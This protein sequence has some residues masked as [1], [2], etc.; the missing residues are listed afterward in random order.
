M[1]DVKIIREEPDKVRNSISTKNIDPKLVDKFLKLDEKWR[2]LTKKIEEK[3]ALQKKLTQSVHSGQ[4]G[5]RSVDK[6]RKNKEETQEL[7]SGLR[8]LE[9]ERE[10]SLLEIPNLPADDVPVGKSESENKV[11]KK[12]GETKKF[13]FPALD[14]LALGEK[15]GIIDTERAAKVSGT[16]FAYLKGD[17]VM[18][19]LALVKLAM[20]TLIK[21]GFIPVIP[22]VL[23]RPEITNGLGYWQAGGRGDYFLA[24]NPLDTSNE[25]EQ[26]YLVGTAEHSLVPMHKDEVFKKKDLPRRY[27]G[28]STCFR[29]E[30]GSYGRDTRGILRVHQFDK[31]EMVSFVPEEMDDEE[32]DKLFSIEEE[33]F[34]SLGIP[35]QVV[36]M[37]SGD[38]GFPVARK[39]DIEAW[40]PGQGK[41]REVTSASTTSDFQA[42]RLNVKYEDGKEKKFARILNGTAFAIGRTIIAILENYQRKDG[43]IEVPKVLQDYVGKKVIG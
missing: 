6:A 32:H 43:K 9:K 1:L 16:R 7:E 19:E 22:P 13:D 31:V 26:Y 23:I 39:Y 41:Y 36:K 4:G 33:L 10:E 24:S 35:Y 37:C 40:M 3:R 25:D 15:A 38:L 2:E 5:G 12:W 30:A 18:L 20:D 8:D 21:E 29:R 28:F 34:Q 17:A 42:R 27:A 14:H 11:I